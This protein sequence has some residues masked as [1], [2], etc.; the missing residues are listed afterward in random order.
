[1]G[2]TERFEE[3]VGGTEDKYSNKKG[4]ILEEIAQLL[5]SEYDLTNYGHLKAADTYKLYLDLCSELGKDPG[6]VYTGRSLLSVSEVREIA[7]DRE[8]SANELLEE[9]SVV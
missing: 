4:D 7:S 1:M 2:F 5:G 9:M 8:E 3:N 6:F